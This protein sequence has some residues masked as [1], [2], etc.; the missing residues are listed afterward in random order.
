MS[1]CTSFVAETVIAA[2]TRIYDNEVASCYIKIGE[3]EGVSIAVGNSPVIVISC[4]EKYVWPCV[5]TIFDKEDD[6]LV[7]LAF[8]FNYA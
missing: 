6:A 7:L 3:Y 8:Y 2:I 4:I 1:R 5:T